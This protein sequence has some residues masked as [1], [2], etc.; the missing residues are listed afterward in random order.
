[1]KDENYIVIQGWMVNKLE[2]KANELLIYALIYGFTQDGETQFTGSQKYMCE[3]IKCTRPTLRKALDSLVEK[4]LVQEEKQTIN[5]VTFNKYK[6]LHVAKKLYMGH[7]ETLHGRGKETLHG[8]GKETLHNNTNK[9]NTI[10]NNTKDKGDPLFN[11][12]AKFGQVVYP[13]DTTNFIQHWETWKQFKKQQFKFTY[14]GNISEQAALTELSKLAAGSENKACKIIAQSISNGWQ[15]LFDLKNEK[16][17]NNGKSF[18]K[19]L[20]KYFSETDPNYKNL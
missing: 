6:T 1:M 11:S 12:R 19:E 5:G 15:G 14:K 20:G 17:K 9:D 4:Q 7:K 10:N 13:F 8:R 2:L 18:N 16:N 3:A